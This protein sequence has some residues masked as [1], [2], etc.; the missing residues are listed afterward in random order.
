M[1][2]WQTIETAPKDKDFFA[3][4]GKLLGIGNYF[5]HVEPDTILCTKKWNAYRDEVRKP[6]QFKRGISYQERYR[7]EEE[8]WE[9]A[10]D[11]APPFED[12]P[13]PKAGEV[14][15][16][17]YAEAFFAYDNSETHDYDGPK[18]FEP[19]HWSPILEPPK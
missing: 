3:T 5:R 18:T 14:K 12:I 4:N 8:A 17:H 9:K 13:N 15:E 10:K 16:W 2:N 6:F 19:T 11:K 1:S 7:L